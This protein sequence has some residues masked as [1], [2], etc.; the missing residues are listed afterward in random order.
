MMKLPS[1]YTEG[2]AKAR[3]IDRETADNYLRHTLIGD[4]VVDAVVEELASL[5]PEE[6]ARLIRAGMDQE[7]EIL[8]CARSFWTPRLPIRPGSTTMP[9]ARGFAPSTRTRWRYSPRSSPAC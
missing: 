6:A 7:E 8:R 3:R 9:S 5:D 1:A 2:Y 4:P